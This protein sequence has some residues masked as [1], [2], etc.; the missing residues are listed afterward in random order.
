MKFAYVTNDTSETSVKNH[1][2]R[3]TTPRETVTCDSQ[4]HIAPIGAILI[5]SINVS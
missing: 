2:H 4:P 5:F 3:C 1:I